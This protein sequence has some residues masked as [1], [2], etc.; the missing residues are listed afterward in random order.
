MDDELQFFHEWWKILYKYWNPPERH[1]HSKEANAFW[2]GLVQECRALPEKYEDNPLF[3]PFASKMT[4]ELVN[5]VQRRAIEI[6]KE[7]R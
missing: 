5:E 1:D 3:Y 6:H 4:L 7:S 2:A